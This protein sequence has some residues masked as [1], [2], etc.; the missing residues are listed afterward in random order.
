MNADESDTIVIASSP[1]KMLLMLLGCFAF[2]AAGCWMWSSADVQNR[3]PPLFVRCVAVLSVGLF[4]LCGAYGVLKLVDGR[5]GLAIDADG[6]V[7]NSSAAAFGRIAWDD[8]AGVRVALVSGQRFV[9]VDL[10]E[11]RKHLDRCGVFQRF[12]GEA[13]TKTTGSPV[14]ISANSLSVPF[15]ELQRLLTSAWEAHRGADVTNRS[16]PPALGSDADNCLR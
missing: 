12:L 9:V 4:G 7:D 15:D 14:N 5:P 1:R 8:I 2:V 3:Y 16:E 6:L 11:P 10:L 13:N